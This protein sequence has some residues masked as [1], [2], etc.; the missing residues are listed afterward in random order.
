MGSDINIEGIVL[1]DNVLRDP[2]LGFHL[3]SL[4]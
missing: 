3:I 4:F 1:V 2:T